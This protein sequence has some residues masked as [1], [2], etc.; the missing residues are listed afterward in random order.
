VRHQLAVDGSFKT[1][2]TKAGNRSIPLLSPSWTK[3][4]DGTGKRSSVAASPDLTSA[5][6]PPPQVILSTGITSATGGLSEQRRK[7]GSST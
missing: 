3:S 2:K 5:S 6:S 4:C 7:Q 1:P